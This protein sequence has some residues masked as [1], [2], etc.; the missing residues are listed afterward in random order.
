MSFGA[1]RALVAA[2]ALLLGCNSASR[3]DT[4]HPHTSGT[5]F[6]APGGAGA[7]S[8]TA[9][10]GGAGGAIDAGV[11]V[12]PRDPLGDDAGDAPDATGD[13]DVA[14]ADGPA[15]AAVDS[16]ADDAEAPADLAGPSEP[17]ACVVGASTIG[18]CVLQ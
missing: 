7:M 1:W 2:A 12:V 8:P 6:G 14:G 10:G 13:A 4:G 17:P 3:Y 15:G 18:S 11:D 5:P 9:D 16:A